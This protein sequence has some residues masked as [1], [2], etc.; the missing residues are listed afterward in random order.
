MV[1]PWAVERGEGALEDPKR[2]LAHWQKINTCRIKCSYPVGRLVRMSSP[3]SKWT[4]DFLSFD[5][6]N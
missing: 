2:S 5:L 1:T 4:I 6:I 3:C